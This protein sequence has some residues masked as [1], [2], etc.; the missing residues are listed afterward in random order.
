M[1]DVA[2]A[3]SKPNQE[4][5]HRHISCALGCRRITDD[6][7]LIDFFFPEMVWTGCPLPMSNGRQGIYQGGIAQV[8]YDEITQKH[9]GSCD[10]QLRPTSSAAARLQF[11][12]AP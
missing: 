8:V 11:H 5:K 3:Q 1:Y 4:Q 6:D 12:A 2:S 9:P 10:D 7:E